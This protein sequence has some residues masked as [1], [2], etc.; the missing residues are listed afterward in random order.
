MINL[1]NVLSFSRLLAV[2]ILLLLA[3]NHNDVAFLV[4]LVF[5][6]VTDGL[7]GYIARKYNLITEFGAKLDSWGDVAIY[8]TLG[9]AAFWL[10]PEAVFAELYYF[11][12][13]L[14]SVIFPTVVGLLKFNSLTSYHT[15]LVKVAAA[16]AVV[17]SIL[18]LTG[19]ANWP[20][21][22]AAVL[23]VLAA[24]E[25]VTITAI[26]DQPRSNVKSIWHVLRN[27]KQISTRS[28]D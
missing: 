23:T 22:I 11:G 24:L 4:L 28:P 14:G 6:I 3:W 18:L 27:Q 2:P 21:R 10:W 19:V 26:V 9:I 5:A 12:A 16:S 20:F 17:S 8:L 1:P 15:W 25:E 13:I 7:D